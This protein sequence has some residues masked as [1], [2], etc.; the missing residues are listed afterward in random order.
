MVVVV[1]GSYTPSTSIGSTAF[2]DF[3]D[4]RTAVIEHVKRPDIA[5]VFPRLLALA[6]SRLNRRIRMRDQITSGTITMTSGR[7]PLPDNLAEII[8]IYH[9]N[10]AEYIAQSPQ[11]K[12]GYCYSVQ[13]D[14]IVSAEISG[15]VSI[16][17]YAVIPPLG[18]T[19]TTSNWLLAKYPDVYL[20]A[21]S[22]EAAKYVHDAE[23]ASVTK[24]LL[25]ESIH[26]AKSDDDAARYA[27]ARVRVNGVTP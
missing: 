24:D 1:P 18:D 10:G 11:H 4:L 12:A 6:E 23:L 13:G 2:N 21:V 25:E 15:D 9:S 3:L 19:V 20:Y 5:D 8:G 27:R 16:D 7:G 17:Y 26:T 22:F 14:D